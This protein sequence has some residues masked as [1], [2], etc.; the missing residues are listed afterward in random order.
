[1]TKL[2]WGKGYTPDPARV[3]SVEDF[4]NPDPVIIRETP[5]KRRRRPRGWGQ[6]EQRKQRKKHAKLAALKAAADARQAA[7]IK[8][9]EMARKA[10]SPEKIAERQA[11]KAARRAAWLA[12]N[13]RFARKAEEANRAIQKKKRSHLE[14]W[15]ERQEGL[16]EKRHTLRE[17]WK[18]TLLR[19]SGVEQP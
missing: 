2:N 17:R 18:A 9:G 7:Q 6:L 10:Q 8:Q 16:C 12:H 11:A 15:A 4:S 14:A 19:R 1:M 13:Q 3:R 5:L